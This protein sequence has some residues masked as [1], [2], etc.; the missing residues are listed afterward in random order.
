[1]LSF[2]SYRWWR[3][4]EYSSCP[5]WEH[6]EHVGWC[7]DVCPQMLLLVWN[8]LTAALVC[9]M[10][11]SLLTEASA[12]LFTTARWLLILIVDSNV[13]FYIL[14]NIPAYSLHNI[15]V[16]LIHVSET[17]GSHVR[18]TSNAQRQLQCRLCSIPS[19]ALLP[20]WV[21]AVLWGCH[22]DSLLQLS[23]CSH[24]V[25]AWSFLPALC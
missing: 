13:I 3:T 8:Q 20:W 12:A 22:G 16:H 9:H 1:M 5:S 25:S 6:L 14:Y 15:H 7:D 11:S 24:H 21:H 18:L 23:S 19:S 4:L 2:P 17:H 10:S